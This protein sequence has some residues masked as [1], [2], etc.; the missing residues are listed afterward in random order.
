MFLPSQ[1][2]NFSHYETAVNR[3]EA[4]SPHGRLAPTCQNFMLVRIPITSAFGIGDVPLRLSGLGI[5]PP[6]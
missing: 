5:L 1:R 4:D 2:R 3:P 6:G